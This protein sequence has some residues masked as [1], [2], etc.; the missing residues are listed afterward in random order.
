MEGNQ[1]KIIMINNDVE[2]TYT[3]LNRTNIEENIYGPIF[4][5][6]MRKNVPTFLHI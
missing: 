1:R 2:N 3:D 4:K 5:G 6:S